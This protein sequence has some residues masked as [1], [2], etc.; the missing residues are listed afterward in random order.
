M[1]GTYLH[2]Q[3][4]SGHQINLMNSLDVNAPLSSQVQCNRNKRLI[5]L[6]A[7]AV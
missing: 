1:N 4:S 6:T 2:W 5:H 7:P 3:Q